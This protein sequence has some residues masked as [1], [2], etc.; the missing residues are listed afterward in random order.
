MTLVWTRR[1]DGWKKT[2]NC[3]TAWACEWRKEQKKKRTLEDKGR[4]GWTMLEKILKRKT[5]NYLRH[6]M[7]KPRIEK[8]GEI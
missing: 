8:F 1:K 3:N 2:T 7:E 6:I 5:Y 4:D